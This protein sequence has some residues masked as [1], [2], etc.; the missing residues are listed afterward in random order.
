MAAYSLAISSFS[1]PFFASVSPRKFKPRL[2][3]LKSTILE[4]FYFSS[5]TKVLATVNSLSLYS[6]FF[7]FKNLPKIPPVFFFYLFLGLR[8]LSITYLS[9]S[10][11]VSSLDPFEAF[12]MTP[13]SSLSTHSLT[14][15]PRS[16]MT[17]PFASFIATFVRVEIC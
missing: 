8:S 14:I 6:A 4:S 13:S 10:R 9:L 2:I 5:L 17:S 7:V 12:L 11:L 16:S 15:L 3:A 1:T